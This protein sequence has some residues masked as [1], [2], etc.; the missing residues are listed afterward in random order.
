MGNKLTDEA[1]RR[2]N[3]DEAAKNELRTIGGIFIIIFGIIIAGCVGVVLLSLLA[4]FI[5]L[6]T[7]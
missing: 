5:L 3:D 2:R 6:F 4:R 7:G 1:E